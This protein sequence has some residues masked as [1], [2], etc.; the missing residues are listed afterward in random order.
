[1]KGVAIGILVMGISLA[2]VIILYLEIGHIGPTYSTTIMEKQQA[3][4][5]KQYGLPIQKPIPKNLLEVPPSLR[6][7]T[8]T[9]NLSSDNNSTDNGIFILI[10][11]M[12]VPFPT[13]SWSL[14]K[15]IEY[16]KKKEYMAIDSK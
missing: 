3:D 13:L 15:L 16:L 11:A 7:L 10:Y 1:M 4:L 6:N 8:T 9:T 14:Q 12:G 2:L 5:R